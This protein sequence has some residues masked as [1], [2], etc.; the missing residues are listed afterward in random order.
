M[1]Q[2]FCSL[3]IFSGVNSG[4]DINFCSNHAISLGDALSRDSWD[5]S[6][7]V[8]GKVFCALQFCMRFSMSGLIKILMEFYGCMG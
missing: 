2:F 4:N 5:S 3:I 1:C 7:C 8:A 6:D